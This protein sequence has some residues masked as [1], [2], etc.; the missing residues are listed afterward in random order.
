MTVE[1][2]VETTNIEVPDRIE[3]EIISRAEAADQ[4]EIGLVDIIREIEEVEIGM[5][6]RRIVERW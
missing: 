6:E 4:I 1:T 3:T 2:V 5:T